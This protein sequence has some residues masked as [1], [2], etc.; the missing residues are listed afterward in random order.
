MVTICLQ[1]IDSVYLSPEV[2]D[3]HWTTLAELLPE[4]EIA[5][6][7]HEVALSDVVQIAEKMVKGEISGRYVVTPSRN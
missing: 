4:S 5:T 2:R 3:A 6:L 7:T 1:G